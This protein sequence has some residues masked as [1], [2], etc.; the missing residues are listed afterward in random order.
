MRD[1]NSHSCVVAYEIVPGCITPCG[2]E[3]FTDVSK[4]RSGLNFMGKQLFGLINPGI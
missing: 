3:N 2:L 1:W 4:D